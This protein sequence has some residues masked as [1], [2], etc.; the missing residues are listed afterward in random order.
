MEINDHR[1]LAPAHDAG[2]A[3]LYYSGNVLSRLAASWYALS[4]VL[5]GLG[6]IFLFISALQ[7]DIVQSFG[8]YAAVSD[9]LG[10]LASIM[11]V[12]TGIIV[13]IEFRQ[14]VS[15]RAITLAGITASLYFIISSVGIL[16]AVNHAIGSLVNSLQWLFYFSG[17]L[18]LLVVSLTASTYLRRFSGEYSILTVLALTLITLG[19]SYTVSGFELFPAGSPS[20]NVTGTLI[21]S[22][23]FYFLSSF[24]TF[25][26]YP[27]LF[28]GGMILLAISA[29]IHIEAK[30]SG[31]QNKESGNV[32]FSIGLVIFSAG[33]LV[34]AV[35]GLVSGLA[36]S[37]NVVYLAHSGIPVLVLAAEF[38][39]FV[40]EMLLIASSVAG[41][42]YA[43]V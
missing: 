40:V 10:A 20:G 6:S 14:G 17:G 8:Y 16:F 15:I 29:K 28:L 32:P 12:S 30:N 2:S 36:A 26:S 23:P 4:L 19:V 43:L 34:S 31:R 33:L 35:I 22:D 21:V 27:L 18:L 13:I 41:I 5:L 25:G 1:S 37:I 7:T 42:M 38:V 3:R 9:G 39:V 11:F 24:G